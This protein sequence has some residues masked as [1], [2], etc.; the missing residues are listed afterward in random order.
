MVCTLKVWLCFEAEKPSEPEQKTE[1][2]EE[3]P[4]EAPQEGVSPEKP[5]DKEEEE[6]R[7]QV[8]EGANPVEENVESAKPEVSA[9]PE[10]KTPE[11]KSAEADNK[12]DSVC[13]FHLFYLYYCKICSSPQNHCSSFL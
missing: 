12:D 8:D 6:E 5:V 13:H 1:V 10:P 3:K 11:E 2:M 4:A 7:M 9:E